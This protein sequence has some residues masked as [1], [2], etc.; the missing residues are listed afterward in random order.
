M[1]FDPFASLPMQATVAGSSSERGRAIMQGPQSGNWSA[2]LLGWAERLFVAAGVAMLAWCALVVIDAIMAQRA[3]RLT[4]GQAA[5]PATSSHPPPTDPAAA[6]PPQAPIVANGSAVAELSI[7]RVRLSVVVLHGSDTQTLRRGPGHLETSPLPGESGNV[8]IAGHRDTFFRPLRDVQVGDDVFLNTPQ[9]HFHY[10][11]TSLRVVSPRDLSVLEPSD[12]AMLTL[13]TCYPFWVFGQ[14]PDRF[15]VHAI[16]LMDPAASSTVASTVPSQD[17]IP[18]PRADHAAP[19]ETVVPVVNP[20][21]GA[22]LQN[23]PDDQTGPRLGRGPVDAAL[24][25]DTL[26][27]QAVER[28][29]LTYNASFVSHNGTRAGGPLTFQPCDVTVAGDRAAATCGVSSAPPDDHPHVRT[30]VLERADGGWSIKSI[31]IE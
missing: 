12:S 27:R 21:D 13:I 7:P 8:V 25:D 18:A 19:T 24:R 23:A 15:V 6:V 14:A 3:G 11:V 20:L 31:I 1:A 2:R 30:F 28:F 26:V 29:R 17:S 4:L 5:P 22:D 9:R 10:R 16:R